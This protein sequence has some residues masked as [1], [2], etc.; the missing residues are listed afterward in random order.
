[1]RSDSSTVSNQDGTARA[2][3][4][5]YA[6]DRAVRPDLRP[7]ADRY[8]SFCLYVCEGSYVCATLG[9][10]AL[11]VPDFPSPPCHPVFVESR[12]LPSP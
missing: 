2:I 10:K 11:G 3:L 4:A 1:M 5:I 12:R 9:S 8:A 6:V 7:F